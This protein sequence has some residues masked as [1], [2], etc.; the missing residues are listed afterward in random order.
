M[1]LSPMQKRWVEA[2]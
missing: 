1:S 2:R